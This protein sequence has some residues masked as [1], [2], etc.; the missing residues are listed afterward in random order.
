M[1]RD[2][3]AVVPVPSFSLTELRTLINDGM[4]FLGKDWQSF[5][6][7]YNFALNLYFESKVKSLSK[8]K[9]FYSS[10]VINLQDIYVPQNLK[11][12]EKIYSQDSFF[13]FIHEERKFVISATAGAGKSCML[14]NMFLDIL[15]FEKP[16]FPL[17]F[18]LRRINDKQES[19]LNSLVEDIS[20]FNNKFSND[21][22]DYILKRENTVL[23]LDGFDEINHNHKEDFIIEIN[24][25]CEVYPNLI[26]VVSSRPE[27]GSF[28]DWS[29]FNIAE[30]EMLSVDQSTLMISKLN[31]DSEVTER[32]INSLVSALYEKHHSFASNPLLLTIMLVTFEKYGEVPEKIHLFYDMAYQTLFT[33]HDNSKQ[34]YKRKSL[35]NLDILE[36]KKVFSLFCLISYSKEKFNFDGDFLTNYLRICLN[37]K[38]YET[39]KE[40][41]L[42]IEL[43]NNIPLIIQDGLNYC[44]S[45][46]SF[47]EYF[48]AYYLATTYNLK[49]EIYENIGHRSLNDGVINLI[50]DM[51]KNLIEEKWVIPQI[52]KILNMVSEEDDYISRYDNT[53]LFY[54]ECFFEELE[55]GEVTTVIKSSSEL[56][57]CHFL[58]E[59]YKIEPHNIYVSIIDPENLPLLRE[60]F[61]ENIGDFATVTN[62]NLLE[63]SEIEKE[64]FIKTGGNLRAVGFVNILKKVKEIIEDDKKNMFDIDSIL[65]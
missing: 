62:L 23:F 59:K 17:F 61:S 40:S 38:G 33:I 1:W 10:E 19:L 15:R 12:L 51:D 55:D 11:F 22:L 7:K 26:V 14:K 57:F 42:K 37:A 54:D 43:M 65:F 6:T 18:E 44:F 8:I 3:M 48:T 36:F 29:Y 25:I 20:K 60:Y 9:V 56:N 41:D 2:K 31:Y 32:F 50:F 46:R 16:Y 34:G 35:T 64:N 30:V 13:N 28:R 45:H 21:N 27:L 24:K 63:L 53:I 49:E 52:D 39:I 47:Q 58:Q 5:A 4:G